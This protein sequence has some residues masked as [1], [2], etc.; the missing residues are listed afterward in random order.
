MPMKVIRQYLRL[1][2][3]SGIILFVMA[4]AA[5]IL[6]NTSWQHYYHAF[7]LGPIQIQFLHIQLSQPLLFWINEGLMTLFFLLVGLEIKREF[8]SG[9]LSDVSDIVLPAMTALGGMLVP[10]LIYWGINYDNPVTSKGWAIP[11]A[12]DIAFA[13]GVLSLFGKRVPL[14]LKLFLMALAIFDDVGAILIIAICHTHNLS[15]LSLGLAFLL[16]I[17]MLLL[18]VMRVKQLTPYLLLGLLL[19]LCVLKSG[20]HATVA[21]VVVALLIP[22]SKETTT[23]RL[24]S[25]ELEQGLHPWVAYLVMPLF[26]LANAG[27][28]FSGLTFSVVFDVIT[29]GV[30]LGLFL[31]KQIGVS[32]FSWL[33]VRLGWATL[34]KNT[35]WVEIYGVAIISGIG[36]TM[37]LFL[38]TLAFQGED[39]FLTEVRLG[40]LAGSIL[41]GI[42]GSI[43]LYFGLR[44]GNHDFGSD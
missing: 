35:H 43:V 37:S 44:K 14:G 26:A 4:V 22:Q 1:E 11:V 13:L 33:M 19:W 21:G 17:S 41:S 38:G 3:A 20:V 25:H 15:Y 30:A 10:A 16:V 8:V 23:G 12:T 29:L 7:F 36:F 28:S 5:L 39:L 9:E 31:G 34:P 27:V 42:I 6:S 18:N 40:V 24:T 32:L 2:A